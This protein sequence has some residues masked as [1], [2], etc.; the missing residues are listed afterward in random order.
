M[1]RDLGR[2]AK[3]RRSHNSDPRFRA[4]AA[5][6]QA[7]ANVVAAEPGTTQRVDAEVVLGACL[8]ELAFAYGAARQLSSPPE[9]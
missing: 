2:G 5:V 9:P 7:W 8:N 3:A 4:G 6:V 1:T